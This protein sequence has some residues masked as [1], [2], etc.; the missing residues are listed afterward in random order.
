MLGWGVCTIAQAWSN[1]KAT[2]IA[3]RLLIGAFESGFYPTAV[4]YLSSFYPRF[5]LAVR[6]ALFYGQYAVAG[7]FGGSI[8]YGIFHIK[9]GKLHNW[10][11]LFIIEGIATCVFAITAW[12]WLP[13]GPGSAWFLNAAD[14]NYSI[15]RIRRDNELYIQ[16]VYEESDIE[17]ERLTSRDWV[18]TG[19][20]WKLW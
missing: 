4:A 20:D 5:D 1:N 17:R 11:W 8:A 9:G 10:Q 16:H 12:F 2:L 14:R 3:A 6:I 18:E 19:K 15:E 13:M 7:A